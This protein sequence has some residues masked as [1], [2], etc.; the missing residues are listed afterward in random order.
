[1]GLATAKVFAEAGAAVVLADRNAA[2]RQASDVLNAEGHRTMAVTLDV[3]DEAQAADGVA[4]S[5]VS[6]S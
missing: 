5:V 6:R 2:V 4:H 3:T 1:M